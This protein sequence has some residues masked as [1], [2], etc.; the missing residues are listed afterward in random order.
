MVTI[1]ILVFDDVEELDFVGPLEVFGMAGQA[2]ADCRVLLVAAGEGEVRCRYGLQVQPHAS[3]ASCPPLDLLIVPGGLGARTHAREHPAILRFV[4]EQPGQIASVCTGAL[5]LAAAGVLHGR[6]V[7]THHRAF[8]L[9]RAYEGVRV[10]EGV[11][12]IFDGPIATSAGVSAGIDLALALA[13]QRWGAA[14]A[15][16]VAHRMEWEGGQQW[17]S[18]LSLA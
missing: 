3:F 11:R 1:G 9:L 17:H 10:E 8:D 6:R 13:A 7:T 16:E 12:F 18:D 2:G 14:L 4:R 15:A 5:I